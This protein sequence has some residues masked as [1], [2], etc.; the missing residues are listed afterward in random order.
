M[1]V[2]NGVRF[3]FNLFE[4]TWFQSGVMFVLHGIQIVVPEIKM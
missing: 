3:K 2:L 4:L 1:E